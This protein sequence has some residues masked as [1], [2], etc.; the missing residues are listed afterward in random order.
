M[1]L[2]IEDMSVYHS[3]NQARGGVEFLIVGGFA[4]TVHGSSIPTRDLDVVYRRTPEN[5]DRLVRAIA[6]LSPYL[7]DAP[8]GLP[9]L[10]DARTI[11]R[12][13][14]FTL[15]TG[16][17]ALD[18]L[19]EIVGGG[20][21]DDLVTHSVEIEVFDVRCRCLGLRKLI[22]VKRAAG[23]V[24]DLQAVAELETLADESEPR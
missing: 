20:G 24:K 15:T 23:R 22:E 8:A 12:G 17:G 1:P 2:I 7:R 6:P 14:N 13:L 11:K 16:A 5:I 3:L 4:G 10:W 21:Y 19:G 18:L 9:F